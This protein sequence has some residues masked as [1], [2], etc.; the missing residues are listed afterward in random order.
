M[1]QLAEHFSEHGV[2]S[3]RYDKVGTGRTGLGPYVGCP[4]DVGSA[5]FTDG[6]RPRRGSWP[7]SPAPM[8]AYISST[9]WA[10]APS[11]R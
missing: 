9:V 5:I 1:R 4:A 11:T 3:L 7:T 6:A 2:A 10:R 8:P